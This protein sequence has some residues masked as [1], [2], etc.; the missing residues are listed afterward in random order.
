[1]FPLNEVSS[2]QSR[3]WEHTAALPSYQLQKDVTIE[4]LMIF[5][6]LINFAFLSRYDS[7][8]H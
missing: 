7:N 4:V 1:M 6:N 8:Y 5:E 2:L 3:R